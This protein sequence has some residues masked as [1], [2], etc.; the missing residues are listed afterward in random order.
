MD[1]IHKDITNLWAEIYKPEKFRD[2]KASDFFDFDFFMIPH[3]IYE[4]ERFIEKCN[5][6]K[7]RFDKNA[8]NSV[9]P[10]LDSKNVPIDGLSVFIDQTWEVIRNQKELNLPD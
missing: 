3:K 9:F 10:K 1:L 5:E 4:E 7:G 2:S 6:L 8:E